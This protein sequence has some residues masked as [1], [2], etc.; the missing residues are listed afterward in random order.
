[1]GFTFTGAGSEV[2]EPCSDKRR[3]KEALEGAGIPTPAWRLCESPDVPGWTRFPAIVK[4][5]NEH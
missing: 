2:L 5:V 1:M 4:P 3:G